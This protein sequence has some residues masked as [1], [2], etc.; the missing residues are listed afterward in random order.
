MSS[1]RDRLLRPLLALIALLTSCDDPAAPPRPIDDARGSA[2]R[3]ATPVT[4]V[5]PAPA[6]APPTR[7]TPGPATPGAITLDEPRVSLPREESFQLLDPGKGRKATLRY[8]LAAGTLASVVEINISSRQL[9]RDGFTRPTALPAIRDGFAITIAAEQPNQLALRALRGESATR[10]PEADAYL[11]PWR[12]LLENRHITAAVD[13]R[14]QLSTITFL[15]DRAG[16]RSARA[17]DELA[18]RL[19]AAIVPLPVE[20]VG[21]GASWRVATVLRQGPAYAKQTA[22]YT[23][24]SRTADRWKLRIKL[25]RVGE[26]QRV[27]DPSLPSGTIADLVALFRLLE[28]DVEVDPTYPLIAAGSLTVESRL[29]VRLQTPQQ[30]LTEQILEDTGKVTFSLCRPTSSPGARGDEKPRRAPC[31]DGL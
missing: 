7:I 6:S 1:R 19:L 5:T 22:T 17:R 12:K 11:A 29:H 31:P 16:T 9:A 25:Q 2:A 3:P 15:D 21:T 18:Q 14:G 27:A 10:S 24:V 28:G 23:L 26:A 8:A 30:P 4:P 13:P 20:P